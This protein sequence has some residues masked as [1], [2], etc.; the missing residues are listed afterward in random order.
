VG[1]IPDEWSD[2][3][4][5]VRETTVTRSIAAL[6][7]FSGARQSLQEEHKCVLGITTALQERAVIA[8][9]SAVPRFLRR[10]LLSFGAHTAQSALLL[11]CGYERR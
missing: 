2:G 6:S 11:S 8:V 7:T 5:R 9:E 10:I 1:G 3:G 4:A